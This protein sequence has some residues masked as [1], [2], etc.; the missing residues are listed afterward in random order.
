MHESSKRTI[1]E[2]GVGD[3]ILHLFTF[4]FEFLYH[5]AP[6]TILIVLLLNKGL[7]TILRQNDFLTYSLLVFLTNII[8]YWISPEIYARY[9]FMLLPLV[10][11]LLISSYFP[12]QLINGVQRKVVDYFFILSTATI[13]LACVA[14]PIIPQLQNTEHLFIKSISIAL[15]LSLLVYF[16]VCYPAE[17]LLGF[18]ISI[19]IFRLGF[20]WLVVENRGR[21][22]EELKATANTIVKYSN[23]KDLYIFNNTAVAGNLDGLTFH[24]ITNRK[25][26]LN[27]TKNI[28]YNAFYITDTESVRDKK[29]VSL[30]QFKNYSNPPLMLVKFV[31]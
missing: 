31:Q 25:K 17:R 3:T 16:M 19:A 6:W 27:S 13:A 12:R 2:K 22:F 18:A 24:I 14:A 5:F 10:F 21:R 29:Y 26:L 15:L 8:I 30:M 9:L 23:N 4:P 20:N 11:T 1:I 28:D 7:R